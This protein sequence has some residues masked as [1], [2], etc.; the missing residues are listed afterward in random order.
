MTGGD[1]G[2]NARGMRL[3]A[4]LVVACAACATGSDQPGGGGY[5]IPTA[6]PGRLVLPEKKVALVLEDGDVGRPWGILESPGALRIYLGIDQGESARIGL[7][8]GTRTEDGWVFELKDPRAL[9]AEL[10]WE[11]GRVGDPCVASLPGG[12]RLLAYAGGNAAGIGL[13]RSPDGETWTRS[14]TPA[15]V[16]E[17]EWEGGRVWHPTLVV[18]PGR[19]L[20]FYMGGDGSGLG[21]AAS[22][23]LAGSFERL[24]PGP[25]FAPAEMPEPPEDADVKAPAPPFDAKPLDGMSVFRTVSA[26]GRTVYGGWYASNS[27]FAHAASFH[28][29]TFSRSNLNPFLED[30]GYGLASPH[31]VGDVILYSRLRK[32]GKATGGRALGLVFVE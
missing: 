27:A 25:S 4:M 17:V 9:E 15:L 28:G 20:L 19:I 23:D 26:L 7:A 3:A 10:E 11:A 12:E 30:E 31:Q 29:L 1:P 22:A 2:R 24:A 16:P 6:V 5:N 21:V 14:P 13:A 8:T 18:E 32:K